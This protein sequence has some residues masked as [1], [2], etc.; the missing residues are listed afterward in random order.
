MEQGRW[1]GGDVR[2]GLA[3]GASE[4]SSGDLPAALLS[5]RSNGLLT[6]LGTR[7]SAG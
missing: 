6:A 3:N 7:S 4:F 5:A 1:R 2:A